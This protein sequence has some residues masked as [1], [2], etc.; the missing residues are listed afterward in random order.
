[1]QEHPAYNNRLQKHMK[2]FWV[3]IIIL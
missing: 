1:M 2:T 3:V